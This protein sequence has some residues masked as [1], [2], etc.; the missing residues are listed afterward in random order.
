MAIKNVTLTVNFKAYDTAAKAY[1]TGDAA[2]INMFII[3]DG[4]APVA[5]TNAETEPDPT[6]VPGTYELV[7]T[8]T[9][10]NANFVWID[11]K[12]STANVIILPIGITTDQGVIAALNNISAAAVNTE[13][14]TALTDINLDH[15]MKVAAASGDIID[16][17]VIAQIVSKEATADWDD[18]VKATDSL[19][20]I[21]E[22]TT[23]TSGGSP[24]DSGTAQAGTSTTLTLRAG[25][26]VVDLAG[27]MLLLTGGTGDNQVR[28]ILSYV[29]ETKVATV[30]TWDVT[31]DV[32]STYE[33][34]AALS[35]NLTVSG[36]GLGPG[37][38]EV[39]LNFLD[40][41]SSNPITDA[42]VWIATDAAM[43]NVI[44]GTLQTNGAGDVTFLLDDGVGYFYSIQK[45]GII[46]EFGVSFVA[47]KD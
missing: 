18:Y 25:A 2:N 43:T 21:G 14:D 44:A 13:V 32:T 9:E 35:V 6:N 27:N 45:D 23:A 7:L 47:I 1:K 19:Q 22:K 26:P 11:G 39:T 12:S 37:A 17:S 46:D 38:D 29:T 30:G 15:L 10:M 41:V 42:D 28:E 16:N 4:G 20:A 36:G 24:I 33:V 8:A 5:A 34:L 3:K 40:D 31:P